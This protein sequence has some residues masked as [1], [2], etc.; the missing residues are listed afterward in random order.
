V[1]RTIIEV[2]ILQTV[3]PSNVNRDDGGTPKTAVYG[4]VRR[5]RVSSQAWKRA[6]RLAFRDLL[7]PADLG[8]RTRRIVEV[9]GERITAQQPALDGDD[10]LT[11]AAEVVRTATGTKAMPPRRRAESAGSSGGERQSA[12]QSPYLV[13]LSTRQLDGLARLAVEGAHDIKAFLRDKDNKARAR[14]IADTRHSV[15]IA[16]FGRM[17]ADTADMNVDA[18]VQVGHALSVHAVDNESDYFTA[19]DDQKRRDHHVGAGMVGR[20]EFNSAT[21]YRYAALDVDRLRDNLG[22]GL[23][24]EALRTEPVCRATRAFLRGF[25]ASMPTGK[26]NAFGN[27]TLPEAVIVTLRSTRPVSFVSAFEEPVLADP[28]TGGYLRSACGRLLGHVSAIERAYGIS[29]DPRWILRVGA[30]TQ[31]LAPLGTQV[32]LDEL[33]DTVSDVVGDRLSGSAA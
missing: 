31:S 20:T 2:H 4:G 11:L 10:A 14:G 33:L 22:V 15:D 26:I 23:R 24:P 3:P 27:H 13:F 18:S 1:S 12:P 5:A 30:A 28:R 17:V 6:T 19:V 16:L 29:G 32:T 25:I 21:L 7:D 9:L 8:V